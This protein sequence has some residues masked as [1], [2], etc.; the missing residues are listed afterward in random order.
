MESLRVDDRDLASLRLVFRLPAPNSDDDSEGAE[1][2]EVQVTVMDRIHLHEVGCP[3]N[4]AVQF[5]LR[6]CAESI[7]CFLIG[8]YSTSLLGGVGMFLLFVLFCSAVCESHPFTLQD[9]RDTLQKSMQGRLRQFKRE[10]WFAS[11]ET[12]R[13]VFRPTDPSKKLLWELEM[14]L[15]HTGPLRSEFFFEGWSVF[16]TNAVLQPVGAV[17]FVPS[18]EKNKVF[19]F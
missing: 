17:L 12:G 2:T 11:G 13:T 7:A 15:P 6:E 10:S 16:E 4:G 18:L 19:M 14:L 9:K 5:L 8:V 3:R 1:D